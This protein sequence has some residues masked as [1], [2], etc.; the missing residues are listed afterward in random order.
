MYLAEKE[1]WDWGCLRMVKVV[2]KKE[3]G[4]GNQTTYCLVFAQGQSWL[5]LCMLIKYPI[6]WIIGISGKWFICSREPFG[7]KRMELTNSWWWQQGSA[8][9]EPHVALLE[10][11]TSMGTWGWRQLSRAQN[12]WQMGPLSAC[13]PG[14]TMA[15]SY[16]SLMRLRFLLEKLGSSFECF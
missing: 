12:R 4:E 9:K 6:Y 13:T 11:V 14:G 8:K 15:F 10:S 2:K 3:K 16:G 7:T 1:Y 5:M